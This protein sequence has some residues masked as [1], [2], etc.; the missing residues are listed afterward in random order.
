MTLTADILRWVRWHSACIRNKKNKH[1]FYDNT[2]LYQCHTCCI[3]AINILFIQIINWLILSKMRDFVVQLK[4]LLLTFLE[5]FPKKLAIS[6]LQLLDQCGWPAE[7]LLVSHISCKR[8][9]KY[10]FF[11]NRCITYTREEETN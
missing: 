2:T 6:P 10:Q 7:Q 5:L 11:L 1:K 9:Y 4:I 8:T 3:Y